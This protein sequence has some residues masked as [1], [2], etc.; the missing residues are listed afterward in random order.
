MVA[1]CDLKWKVNNIFGIPPHIIY[2]KKYGDPKNIFSVI[3]RKRNAYCFYFHRIG[4]RGVT[5][6]NMSPEW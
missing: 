3:M 6:D 2:P 4:H 1:V 5:D